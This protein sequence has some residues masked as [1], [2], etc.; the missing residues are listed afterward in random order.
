MQNNVSYLTIIDIHSFHLHLINV[1]LT[2]YLP[3]N[4]FISYFYCY[5]SM[6]AHLTVGFSY[7]IALP[8]EKVAK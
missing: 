8:L 4:L 3:S 7:P 5:S 6:S 2:Y 1:T